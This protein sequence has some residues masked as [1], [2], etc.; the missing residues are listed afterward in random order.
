MHKGGNI[1]KTQKDVLISALA[2]LHKLRV[3]E[4][5]EINAALKST[6]YEEL[7]SLIEGKY[8]G[9]VERGIITK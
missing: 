3:V 4:V 2:L 9:L 8:K 7:F 5:E 6:G 1:S